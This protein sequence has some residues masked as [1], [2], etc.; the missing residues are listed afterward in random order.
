MTRRSAAPPPHTCSS[1][2]RGAAEILGV[3]E[4]HGLAMGAE[5]R[6]AATED[7]C[8]LRAQLISCGDDV[9]DLVAKVVYAARGIAFEKNRA[10]ARRR[11][12]A[13]SW[14]SAARQKPL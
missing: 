2:I 7:P 4:Q 14:C 10:P 5:P 3:Q 1:S 6:R 9:L 13:R 8:T 12:V 11:R